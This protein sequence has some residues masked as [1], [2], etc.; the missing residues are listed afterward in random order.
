V[1]LKFQFEAGADELI[2]EVGTAEV[3]VV[4]DVRAEN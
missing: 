3:G 2:E 4:I 1:V